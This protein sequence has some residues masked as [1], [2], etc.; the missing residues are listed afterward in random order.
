MNTLQAV[1]LM[2]RNIPKRTLIPADLAIVCLWS[3]LGLLLTAIILAPG[4]GVEVGQALVM[5]G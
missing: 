5:A 2:A 4:F 1:S 3:A